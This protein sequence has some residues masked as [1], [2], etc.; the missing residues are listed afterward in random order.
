MFRLIKQLRHSNRALIGFAVAVAALWMLVLIT[1]LSTL[2]AYRMKANYDNARRHYRNG[3]VR[4]AINALNRAL[5]IDPRFHQAYLLAARI[6]YEAKDYE[7]AARYFRNAINCGGPKAMGQ[8][9]LAVT[10]IMRNYLPGAPIDREGRNM[11]HTAAENSP[12]NGDILVNL[13]SVYLHEGLTDKALEQY[14]K[15][16]MTRNVTSEGLVCLYTGKGVALM[17]QAAKASGARRDAL[18]S[19]AVDYF[20]RAEL[21]NP[22]ERAAKANRLQIELAAVVDK[23][24]KDNARRRVV[25]E[26]ER[27][28]EANKNLLPP[29]FNYVIFHNL[30]VKLYEEGKYVESVEM[31]RKAAE[32][33]PLS[34]VDTFNEV[35]ARVTLV[36]TVPL[37]KNLDD[38]RKR[39]ERLESLKLATP[40]EVFAMLAELAAIEYA[41]ARLDVSLEHYK[42][43]EQLITDE[44]PPALAAIV[45]RG[46]AVLYTEKEDW[47][48]AL[49]MIEA[50]RNADPKMDD[51]AK[52]TKRL[53]EPPRVDAPIIISKPDLPECFR[54][55]KTVAYCRSLPELLEAGDIDFTF[56][57][58][59]C[60][61]GFTK[62]SGVVALPRRP[63]DE[64]A[65]VVKVKATDSLGNTAQASTQWVLDKTPPS[66]RVNPEPDSTLQAGD[67]TF[68]VTL[69]DAVAGVDYTS[70][71]LMLVRR[72][73]S[74]T[75]NSIRIIEKGKF[76]LDAGIAIVGVP[77]REDQFSV[78]LKDGFA[79]GTYIFLLQ[80]SDLQ[81]N[82]MP[83]FK[84]TYKVK[85]EGT[86]K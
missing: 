52:L 68:V 82:K 23:S 59:P 17:R 81:Y 78:T 13:G 60:V 66:A 73:T 30:A 37:Q 56:G 63:L 62:D 41:E 49:K 16:L 6:N 74:A 39:V 43:L 33:N 9:E 45:Y 38:T 79:P 26:A 77:V 10:L 11:L 69:H 44:I 25:V 46:L 20:K 4:E 84:W 8:E 7:A 70:I 55:A 54:V 75:M 5:Q 32:T 19:E 21:L 80:V 34:G 72:P 22:A 2:S 47:P 24:T 48:A 12:G 14:E 71:N 40:A 64:G 15:A 1:F 27:F 67:D 86:E 51:F 65:H 50:A 36:R 61:V 29:S 85:V 42:Q 57:S 58:V 76:T 83:E 3:N 28:Y 53:S 35:A 31:F 18:L